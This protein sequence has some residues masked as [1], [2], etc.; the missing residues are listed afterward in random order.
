MLGATWQ[1]C[2]VYFMRNALTYVPEGQREMVAA[3]TRAAAAGPWS[4]SMNIGVLGV[5]VAEVRNAS[6]V[7]AECFVSPFY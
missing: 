1:R 2:R 5:S 3:A 6:V 7:F 4:A